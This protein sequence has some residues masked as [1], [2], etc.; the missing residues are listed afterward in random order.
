MVVVKEA[1]CNSAKVTELVKSFI[2]G[3]EQVTDVG[4]ELSLILPSASA[5]SFPALFDALEGIV[6]LALVRLYMQIAVAKPCRQGL[7]EYMCPN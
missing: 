4:A 1:Q 2:R 6:E 5:S 3:A 7:L